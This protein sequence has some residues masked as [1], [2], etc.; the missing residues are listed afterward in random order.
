MKIHMQKRDEGVPGVYGNLTTSL[1]VRNLQQAIL[2]YVGLDCVVTIH[3]LLCLQF[4]G[5]KW[6]R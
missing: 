5:M 6:M 4:T 1:S 3:L 2:E